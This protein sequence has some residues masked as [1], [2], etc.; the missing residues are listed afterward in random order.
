[1][2]A[3]LEG[4]ALGRPDSVAKKAWTLNPPTL[5]KVEL[6]LHLDCCL[7][8][9]VVR[10]LDPTMAPCEVWPD[11]SWRHP[12]CQETGFTDTQVGQLRS[13]L[14]DKLN[15]TLLT[16]ITRRIVA[17]SDPQQIILFGSQAP[18]SR[19]GEAIWI[20]S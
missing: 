3:A 6:H 20:C 7:S 15:E 12:E 5:P 2:G 19:A 10:R 9:D 14:M 16:E 1:M 8:Y 18:G 4:H 11:D 17:V 13:L